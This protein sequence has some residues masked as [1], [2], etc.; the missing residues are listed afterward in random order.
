MEGSKSSISDLLFIRPEVSGYGPHHIVSRIEF[1]VLLLLLC[2]SWGRLIRGSRAG[3]SQ[4][5]TASCPAHG[6]YGVC[7][8]PGVCGTQAYVCISPF[9]REKCWFG[10]RG[11]LIP[12]IVAVGALELIASR[13][14]EHSSISGVAKGSSKARAAAI[15]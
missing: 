4:L 8:H 13:Q 5:K 15:G 2:S 10:A 9:P 11:A 7:L 14:S 3:G 12:F 6:S 1:V